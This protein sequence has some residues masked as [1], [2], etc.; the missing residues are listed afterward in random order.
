MVIIISNRKVWSIIYCGLVAVVTKCIL[1]VEALYF[2][3]VWQYSF[4]G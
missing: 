3:L 1:R 4:D 2:G